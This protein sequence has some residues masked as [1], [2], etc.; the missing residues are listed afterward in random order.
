MYAVVHRPTMEFA[1]IAGF[2]QSS[3]EFP[4][5]YVAIIPR[6]RQKGLARESLDLC[7]NYAND[8]LG[9]NTIATLIKSEHKV[10]KKIVRKLGFKFKKFTFKNG[11]SFEM[12][13]FTS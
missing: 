12:Y 7:L 4:E 13:V 10:G 6:F 3:M 2:I 11:K 1:G 5:I 9:K 8:V